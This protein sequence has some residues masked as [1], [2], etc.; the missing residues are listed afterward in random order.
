[1]KPTIASL[2]LSVTTIWISISVSSPKVYNVFI[3][4]GLG[5][6]WDKVVWY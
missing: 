5:I 1:M 4:K 2:R 6:K 3:T